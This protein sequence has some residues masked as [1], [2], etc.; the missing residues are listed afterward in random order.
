VLTNAR[1]LR[2]VFVANL[3]NPR[4]AADPLSKH[5]VYLGSRPDT[6]EQVID[7][8]MAVAF[9]HRRDNVVCRADIYNR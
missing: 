5:S 1:G 9:L 2:D 3:R 8:A 4:A 6:C 7:A